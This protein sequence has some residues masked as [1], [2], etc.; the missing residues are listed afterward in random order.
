M[1]SPGKRG[2]PFTILTTKNIRNILG[3]LYYFPAKSD[4]A[5]AG[6]RNVSCRKLQ[7]FAEIIFMVK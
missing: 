4:Q 7:F 2:A 3:N 1:E 5:D 6:S